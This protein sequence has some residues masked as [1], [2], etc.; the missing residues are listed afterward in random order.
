MDHISSE[1]MRQE[2]REPK[3]HLVKKPRQPN[4][5]KS[6]I[7]DQNLQFVQTLRAAWSTLQC[8]VMPSPG[9]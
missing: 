4:N 5:V 6:K 1:V 3:E 2:P 8:A 7:L 9:L